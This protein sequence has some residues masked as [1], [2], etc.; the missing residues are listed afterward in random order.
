M[1]IITIPATLDHIRIFNIPW[2]KD[3]KGKGLPF[4]DVHQAKKHMSTHRFKIGI[5]PVDKKELN[6]ARTYAGL[7][8]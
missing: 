3:N 6:L 4:K 7:Q 5:H 8:I 2:V 1:Y